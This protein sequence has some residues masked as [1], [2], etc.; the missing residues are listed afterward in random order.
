MR[1]DKLS[2]F[3]T[4]TM[5]AAEDVESK[6]S[7]KLVLKRICRNMKCNVKGYVHV[8]KIET[9]CDGCGNHLVV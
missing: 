5:I 2:K 8:R 1:L 9:R 7:T 6:H 3:L 4:K